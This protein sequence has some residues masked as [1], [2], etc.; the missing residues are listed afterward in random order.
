MTISERKVEAAAKCFAEVLGMAWSGLRPD[1]RCTDKGFIPFRG[2]KHMNAR[3]EDY[4][5]AARRI[6]EAAQRVREEQAN[7]E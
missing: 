3:Q 2:G 5:D 6:L 1:G 7:G 4:K